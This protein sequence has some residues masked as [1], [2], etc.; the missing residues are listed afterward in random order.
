LPSHNDWQNLVFTGGA[1]GQP[2][3]QPILPQTTVVEE[4]NQ[5]EDATISA[6]YDVALVASQNVLLSPGVTS[7]LNLQVTNR[8]TAADTYTISAA[9]DVPWIDLAAVPPTVSLAPNAVVV[10][11]V[12]AQPPVSSIGQ[13]GMMTIAVASQGNPLLVDAATSHLTVTPEDLAFVGI[14]AAAALVAD[15]KSQTPVS[16]QVLDYYSR[17]VAGAPVTLATT[18]G[19]IESSVVSAANGVATAKLTAGTQVGTARIT[20]QALGVS[21]ST[22]VELVA[23][24]PASLELTP[25]AATMDADG[26]SSIAINFRVR[27]AFANPV[28]NT[29][30][31]F[32]TTLGVIAPTGTTNA[33]GIGSVQFNSVQAIGTA[34][35]S[36]EVGSIFAQTSVLLHGEGLA[37]LVFADL[38][39]NSQRDVGEP[40]INGI[41]VVATLQA[42]AEAA[43]ATSGTPLGIAWTTR[44]NADGVYS[45]TELPFGQYLVAVQIPAN[46]AVFTPASFVVQLGKSGATGPVVGMVSEVTLPYVKR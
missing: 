45:F 19:T 41:A 37:G 31:A 43:S 46:S 8:G 13:T 36:A 39:R 7:V 25:E 4:I 16:V 10:F 17:P 32:S 26:A 6:V 27:D 29:S 20:A 42:M 18:L 38:N 23:G 2:G 12:S 9:A 21:A 30:V 35:I 11:P 3:A 14:S 15:G 1:I 22:E 44:T 34:T 33:A 5:E 24:S 40:G 28:P